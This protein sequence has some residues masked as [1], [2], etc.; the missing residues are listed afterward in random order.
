MIQNGMTRKSTIK[1]GN[2]VLFY[3][4]QDECGAIMALAW[5]ILTKDPDIPVNK[6]YKI[7][8]KPLCPGHFPAGYYWCGSKRVGPECPPKWADHLMITDQLSE[9]QSDNDE[10]DENNDVED[11]ESES[12]AVQT[13]SST[14]DNDKTIVPVA[15]SGTRRTKTRTIV[16]PAR[17][18]F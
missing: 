4:P 2:W 16:P 12:K 10:Y 13:T 11:N 8:S 7:H 5:I 17:Y 15:T 9:V 6:V 18:L 1:L 14:P 3:F